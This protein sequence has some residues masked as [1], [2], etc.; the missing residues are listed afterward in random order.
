MK[1]IALAIFG[2]GTYI[3]SVLS[4]AENLEGASIAPT[5]LITISGVA[6]LVFI[7]LA[8]IRLW[9]EARSLVIT[10]IVSEVIF[11]GFT[12][13]QILI[14]APYGSPVIVLMNFAK[15]VN[16]IAFILVIIKFFGMKNNNQKNS[17]E[18]EN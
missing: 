3:L 9:K 11:F 10:Y 17:I 13:T 6:T 14:L 7:I 18:N 4:S 2:I 8:T 5:S 16:F 15:I 12:I 1:N